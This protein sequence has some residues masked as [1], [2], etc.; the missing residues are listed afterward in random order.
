M[1]P[2]RG[3]SAYNTQ[4]SSANPAEAAQTAAALHPSGHAHLLTSAMLSHHTFDALNAKEAQGNKEEQTLA[5][6]AKEAIRSGRLQ[7][8]PNQPEN[9][10]AQFGMRRNQDILVIRA[11]LN[12][13]SEYDVLGV[14][15][16]RGSEAPAS[17]TLPSPSA[18]MARTAR[19]PSTLL[20]QQVRGRLERSAHSPHDQD[21]PDSSDD[22][23]VPNFAS[24]VRS[25]N[26]AYPP[27]RCTT[28]DEQSLLEKQRASD[29]N[30]NPED[31]NNFQDAI[32]AYVSGDK[33][34]E[35]VEFIAS[36]MKNFAVELSPIQGKYIFRGIA[37]YAE[38]MPELTNYKNWGM[39][40]NREVT[41]ALIHSAE[42]AP[43]TAGDYGL[44]S[45]TTVQEI[46]SEFAASRQHANTDDGKASNQAILNILIDPSNPPRG[47]VLDENYPFGENDI[48]LHEI[49]LS[50]D[51][52]DY[53][54]VNVDIQESGMSNIFILASGKNQAV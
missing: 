12:E 25:K 51:N 50:K 52:N 23:L 4:A 40:K 11:K 46:A 32:L 36:E 5:R 22:E 26:N 17:M 31:A 8:S 49:Q 44:A 47:Y 21:E 53:Q 42:F 54:I 38:K 16:R 35:T 34:D 10:I 37:C 1:D 15:F 18:A 14:G 24:R 6:F 43:N 7:I 20:S 39:N 41:K 3:S 30:K 48:S 27:E 13:R 29:K 45:I 2:I 9:G 28:P 19:Q 33:D